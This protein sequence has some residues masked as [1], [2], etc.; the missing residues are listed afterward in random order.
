MP[1]LI[2]VMPAEELAIRFTPDDVLGTV[3]EGRRPP[4]F[5]RQEPEASFAPGI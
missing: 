4:F 5:A 3:L 2:R 1:R